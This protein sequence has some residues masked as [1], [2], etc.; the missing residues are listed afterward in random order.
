M[1]TLVM[2]QSKKKFKNLPRVHPMH[3]HRCLLMFKWPEL[4]TRTLPAAR[5]SG[6]MGDCIIMIDLEQ[7]QSSV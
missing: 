2:S 3:M 5:K 7:S 6:K 1:A 4:V